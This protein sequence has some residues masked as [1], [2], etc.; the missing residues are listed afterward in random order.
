VARSVHASQSLRQ[1]LSLQDLLS[2][3]H[4]PHLQ[5]KTAPE[6]LTAQYTAAGERFFHP[7][8]LTVAEM[9]QDD[10]WLRKRKTVIMYMRLIQIAM[11]IYYLL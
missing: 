6:I 4:L 3:L 2:L 9:K 7:A 1:V 11:A 5:G 10:G 8:Q